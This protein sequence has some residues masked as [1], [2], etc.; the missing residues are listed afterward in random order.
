MFTWTWEDDRDQ[1]KQ[2]IEVDFEESGGVTTVRFTHSSLWDAE[3]VRALAAC[4]VFTLNRPGR[5]RN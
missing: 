4:P 2:L 3:A 5:A 1:L